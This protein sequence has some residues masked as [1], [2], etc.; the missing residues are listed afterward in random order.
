MNEKVNRTPLDIAV[1]WYEEVV[2][3]RRSEVEMLDHIQTLC[4]EGL[5]SG[6]KSGF[7]RNGVFAESYIELTTNDGRCHKFCFDYG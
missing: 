4:E 5:Y 6:V 2:Y 1:F 7:Y 3:G